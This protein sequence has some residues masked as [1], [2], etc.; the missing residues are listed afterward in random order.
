MKIKRRSPIMEAIELH[1]GRMSMSPG[2]MRHNHA[3]HIRV[4][5]GLIK[6]YPGDWIVADP[7]GKTHVVKRKDFP[8]LFEVVAE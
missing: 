1:E 4:S 3:W 5:D 7:D 2:V 8:R 6:V